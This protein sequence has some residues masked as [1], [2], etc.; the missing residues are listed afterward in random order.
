LHIFEF[1]RHETVER[2][3]SF[4]TDWPLSA[5]ANDDDNNNN[6]PETHHN[7]P[8]TTLCATHV[9]PLLEAAAATLPASQHATT[10]L[11][12]AATAGMRLVAASEQERLYR[13]V[14]ACILEASTSTTTTTATAA[15]TATTVAKPM[16]DVQP[17]HIATLSGELEGYYGAVAANYLEG[18]IRVNLTLSPLS[19]SSSS[20]LVVEPHAVATPTTTTTATTKRHCPRMEQSILG[21]LDMG[22]SSTQ[23]VFFHAPHNA[24]RND[25]QCGPW[26]QPLHPQQFFSTSYLSYGVDQLRERL[27]DL[28]VHESAQ[29][30]QVKDD[31][32]LPVSNPCFN[33]GFTTEWRSRTLM[34]IGDA[35]LCSR[36]IQ[37]LL[38]RS[39]AVHP[40]SSESMDTTMVYNTVGGISH[41]PVRG[42]RFLAMSLYF[43]SLDAL[44]VLTRNAAL[45]TAWPTPTLSELN[46]ALPTLCAMDWATQLQPLDGTHPYTRASVLP[47]RCFEAVYMVTLLRHGFGFEADARDITYAFDVND[48]E[49]EWTLG[50]ALQLRA[51]AQRSEESLLDKACPNQV[52]AD[53]A[54]LQVHEPE[55]RTLTATD[56]EDKDAPPPS[57]DCSKQENATFEDDPEARKP[58]WVQLVAEMLVSDGE[59]F[60]SRHNDYY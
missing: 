37:R 44:R 49:V 36:Y 25:H 11:Y 6:D 10:P 58:L 32:T 52:P 46:A 23:M 17:W 22:G 42:R 34:G 26:Q 21:A 16:F 57:S 48:S 29:V 19:S 41:P 60:S 1:T 55:P 40:F 2:R 39:D 7:D 24:T 18:T 47:H 8:T 54:Q 33:A 13:A 38:P 43:F 59:L 30:G 3:G 14:Y 35:D 53:E 9:Q 15:T 50:M 45:A 20:A 31:S 28:L 51:N 12:Y 56:D 4:R 27:W 5:Y